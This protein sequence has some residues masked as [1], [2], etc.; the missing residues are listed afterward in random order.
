MCLHNLSFCS[1]EILLLILFQNIFDFYCFRII[2]QF[3]V[4]STSSL[5]A[6]SLI[7]FYFLFH[8][9]LRVISFIEELWKFLFFILCFF[10]QFIW[11]SMVRCLFYLLLMLFEFSIFFRNTISRIGSVSFNNN[12]AK[13]KKH[14]IALASRSVWS[15]YNT[16]KS[17]NPINLTSLFNKF[18]YRCKSFSSA[19]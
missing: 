10:I 13:K 6:L 19:A 8:L 7:F 3:L 17:M 2:F 11:F 14:P 18:Y 1:T 15:K 12:N 4:K 16:A 9:W 5:S